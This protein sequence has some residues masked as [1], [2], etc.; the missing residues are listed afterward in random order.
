MATPRICSIPGCGKPHKARGWCNAHWQRWN[1][2]GSP[3]AGGTAHG[4]ALHYLHETVVPFTGSGCLNWPYGRIGNGYAQVTID[5]KHELVSRVV[6]YIVYG[7]P[8]SPTHEAAHSCGKGHEGCVNP[9][10]LRWAT[11]VENAGDR[12]PHGTAR[13]GERQ[14]L[15][16]LTEA[17]VREIRDLQGRIPQRTIAAHYGVKAGTVTSIFRRDSWA[18]VE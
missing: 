16:K 10:H 5:G 9:N 8:P 11:A 2:H 18:W 1:S 12:V 7:Q 13:R 15:A 6:C 14:N 3:L 17:Q 4:A